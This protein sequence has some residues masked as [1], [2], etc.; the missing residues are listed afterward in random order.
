MRKWLLLLQCSPWFLLSSFSS[1][2]GKSLKGWDLGVLQGCTPRST[3]DGDGKAGVV[4][5]FSQF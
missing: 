1:S 4:P 3:G 5:G 2:M